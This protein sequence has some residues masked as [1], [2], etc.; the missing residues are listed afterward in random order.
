MARKHKSTFNN[1]SNPPSPPQ[2][3]GRE[4]QASQTT[5]AIAEPTQE[6]IAT[7][8]YEIF[9]ARGGEPGHNEEDWYQAERELKL[10]KH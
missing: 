4:V 8:A 10:G 2:A 1:N 5:T 7:R 6:Q 3:P 9:L